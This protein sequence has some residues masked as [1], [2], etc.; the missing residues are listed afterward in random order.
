MVFRTGERIED[1][2]ALKAQVEAH[3][4]VLGVLLVQAPQDRSEPLGI[5]RQDRHDPYPRRR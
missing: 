3:G 2:I 1:G 4:L 5:R